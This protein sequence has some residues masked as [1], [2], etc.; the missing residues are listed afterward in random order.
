MNRARRLLSSTQKVVSH[1]S[2]PENK[3]RECLLLQVFKSQF[4]IPVMQ[5]F[6][7]GDHSD[8]Q[9]EGIEETGLF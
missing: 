1:K 5:F 8:L 4:F 3:L 2:D 6:V 9:T 7:F